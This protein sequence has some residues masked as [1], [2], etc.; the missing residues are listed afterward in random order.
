MT[1]ELD[2][3]NISFILE[4]IKEIK[5][6]FLEIKRRETTRKQKRI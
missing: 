3:V 2:K 5:K 1:V 4:Q 6:I